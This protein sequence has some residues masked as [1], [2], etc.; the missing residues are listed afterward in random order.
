MEYLKK[1]I[2]DFEIHSAA[3]IKECFENRKLFTINETFYIFK[4]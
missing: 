3:G 2:K 4:V 1:I